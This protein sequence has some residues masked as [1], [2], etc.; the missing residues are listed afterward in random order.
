MLR[1]RYSWFAA[2]T[3]GVD[4]LGPLCSLMQNSYSVA[5]LTPLGQVYCT[6][7]AGGKALPMPYD[8]SA[9]FHAHM[10]AR[11]TFYSAMPSLP[12]LSR[13][14]GWPAAGPPRRR[15]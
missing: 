2:H 13:R 14:G 8:K 11:F 7:V 9:A 10:Q 12:A 1:R 3:Q 5:A 15:A 4:F 6:Y